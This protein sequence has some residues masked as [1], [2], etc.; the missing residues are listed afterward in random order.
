MHTMNTAETRKKD[1]KTKTEGKT[2]LLS[3]VI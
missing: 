1:K 3:T 2:A